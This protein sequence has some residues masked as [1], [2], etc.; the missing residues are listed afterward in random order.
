[1]DDETIFQQGSISVTKTMATIS[2]TSYPI[3]GIG[4]ISIVKEESK[5]VFFWIVVVVLALFGWSLLSAGEVLVGLV[6]LGIASGIGW[7]L[8]S[9]QPKHHLVIRTASG[10]TQALTSK[11]MVHLGKVKSAIEQAVAAR[12]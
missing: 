4:S 11:D 10:D 8:Y 7:L 1:M 12:G 3:N 5:S 9:A 2:G 6:T